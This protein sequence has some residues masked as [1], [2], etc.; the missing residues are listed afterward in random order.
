MRTR[1]SEDARELHRVDEVDEETVR[2]LKRLT[3]SE[4]LSEAERETGRQEVA[5]LREL[6]GR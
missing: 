5:K 3:D 1:P 4:I 2:K 6:L